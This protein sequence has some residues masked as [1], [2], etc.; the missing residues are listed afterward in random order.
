MCAD[1]ILGAAARE[2]GA[3]RK[4][5]RNPFALAAA[6]LVWIL[7]SSHAASATRDT[8]PRRRALLIG[9]NEYQAVPD[10]RGAINDV[11]AVHELLTTRL[12][13]LAEDIETLTDTDADRKGILAAIA[14]LAERSGPDD[15]VYLHYSG[16]GSQIRDS[17]GDEEDG[18]DETLIPQ[19][20]RTPGVADITDDELAEALDAL[21]G[22]QVVIVLDSCHSGT[23]TRG[24]SALRSRWVPP[25]ERQ[26]LY[27]RVATRAVVPLA[28]GKH[29]LLTGAA[30]DQEA[31]D[32]PV[33]GR[34]HGLFSYSLVRSLSNAPSGA[35]ARTVL[36]GAE[37]ELARIQAQLGLRS[38]PEPQ[39]EAAPGRLDAALFPAPEASAAAAEVARLPWLEVAPV[40]PGR[41]RLLRGPRLGAVPG[42]LWAIHPPGE[43]AF[44]PGG[45]TAEAEV[46]AIRDGDAIAQLA[47]AEARV[48]PGSRA[49][50][51][52]PAP[53]LD[54]VTVRLEDSD[55]A[56]AG[57]LREA[58]SARLAGVE[59]VAPDA[60]ARFVVQCEAARC[61]VLGAD[62]RHEVAAFEVV[63]ATQLTT[64]LAAVLARS[65]TAAELL[66]LDNPTARLRLELDVTREGGRRFRIR[67]P[68]QAR[69]PDNSLQLR[70]RASAP[71]FLTLVDVDSEGGIQVLFPNPL[72]EA[73]G[74]Y[75]DG[76]IPA[77]RD[78]LIPD[79]LDSGNRAGF[80]LDY[81]PPRGTDTLRAF[82]AADR[83]VAATLRDAIASLATAGTGAAAVSP[84]GR[85]SIRSALLDRLR[86]ALARVASRGVVLVA[87]EPV[88]LVAD[89]PSA[90]EPD[91]SP[92][93]SFDWTAASLTFEVGD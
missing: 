3:G 6:L 37:Q 46:V 67:R 84:D 9:I 74:Y 26:A 2:P 65:M 15:V 54:R 53:A 31:L 93:R 42:S 52:A 60:F 17:N 48:R 13:F 30:Q 51:L 85:R 32:G 11:E 41:V 56:R 88:V 39:L 57:R 62:G 19:D 92:A 25:D 27:E 47:P 76:R 79:S 38:M 90:E 86:P 33:D 10:L 36:R 91:A 72:S 66:S 68:G 82:C 22:Q 5:L 8:E 29:V 34:L 55:P 83:V 70:A 7:A 80:H 87:D 78:V 50:A 58:L 44:E 24:A 71:C 20:G 35:D 43:R 59:F 40:S 4:A 21:R 63:S 16:H 89:E 1:A 23:A 64:A 69:T 14:R 75:P 18:R 28:R 73:R 81:A 45:A 49:V 12:G 61:R 77:E